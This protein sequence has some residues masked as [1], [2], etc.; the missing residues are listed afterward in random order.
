M[1][2]EVEDLGPE[3]QAHVFPRQREL[4]DDRKVRV[5]EVGTIYGHTIGVA[6][7]ALRGR[8][9]ACGINVLELG[10]VGV[11][12]ATRDLVR[13]VEVVSVTAVVEENSGR[14]NAVDQGDRK[15][16]RDLLDQGQLPA[17]EKRVGCVAPIAPELLAPAERQIVNDARGEAVV[18]VDL[19]ARPVEVLPVR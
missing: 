7:E 16:G 8:D 9:E 1:V 6:K 15:A 14:V 4:L 2:E 19:R 18:E 13:T 5:H 17:S 11:N 10:V 3:I 12:I